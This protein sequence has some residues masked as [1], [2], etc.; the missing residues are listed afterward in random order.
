MGYY[1]NTNSKGEELAPNSKALQLVADGAKIVK[2]EW[3][4][5]L[6]C[7]VENGFFDAAGYCFN[8][9]EFLHFLNDG[10]GRPKTWL[11]HPMAKD[12]AE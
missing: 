3:Q 5:N 11:V 12:L 2:P 6:V 8:E 4:E 9:K 1:I 10:S 7:V